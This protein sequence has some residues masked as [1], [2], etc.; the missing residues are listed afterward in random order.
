MNELNIFSVIFCMHIL[1]YACYSD[2]QKR[3]VPNKLWLLMIAV[4]IPIAGYNIFISGMPFLIRFIFS[5]FFTFVLSYLFFRFNLFGGADAK[6][7]IAI[8]VLIP[9]HPGFTLYFYTHHFLPNFNSYLILTNDPFPFAI[10]TLLN[11]AIVSLIV[12]IYMIS[13]NLLRLH[14]KELRENLSSAF[15]GY[16]L[17]IDALTDTNLSNKHVRLI[18]LYENENEDEDAEKVEGGRGDVKRKF[19][20][21]GVEI[22]KEEVE[23]LKNYHAQG[24]IGEDVWVTPE[25]PFMLF[26][27]SGFVISLFYGN[28]ISHILFILSM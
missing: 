9:V 15:I 6:C 8:S 27:T 5:I 28:L 24:K 21:G 12:P 4:G 14:P 7:L 3:S 22:D 13:Y 16:K 2:I 20:F 18:H 25:L 19:V 1:I 23:R 11:A 17:P 10:T 26:I